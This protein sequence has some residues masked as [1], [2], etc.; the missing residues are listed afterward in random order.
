MLHRQFE[1]PGLTTSA[2]DAAGTPPPPPTPPP[3]TR[4]GRSGEPHR[5]PLVRPGVW[6]EAVSAAEDSPETAERR[7]AYAAGDAEAAVRWMRA[8]VRSVASGLGPLQAGYVLAHWVHGPGSL[9]DY[10]RLNQGRP[11]ALTVY[12]DGRRLTWRARPVRLVRLVAVNG[13]PPCTDA[14]PSAAPAGRRG[15][16]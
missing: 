6:C 5:T 14:C 12:R 4:G 13:R 1:E 10:A 2:A 15:R 9:E 8:G 16:R 11:C 7:D 3:R